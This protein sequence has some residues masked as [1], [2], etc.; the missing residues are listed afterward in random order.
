M[1]ENFANENYFNDT[2]TLFFFVTFSQYMYVLVFYCVQFLQMMKLEYMFI[3][4]STFPF[5]SFLEVLFFDVFS[6]LNVMLKFPSGPKKISVK[7]TSPSKKNALSV[8]N[9]VY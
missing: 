2:Q 7:W 5:L 4:I 6:K 3:L 9:L 8:T 1:I